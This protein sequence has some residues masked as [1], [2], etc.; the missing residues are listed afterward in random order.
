MASETAARL[1]EIDEVPAT[2]E[3]SEVSVKALQGLDWPT[4]FARDGNGPSDAEWRHDNT[5]RASRAL[6]AVAAYSTRYGASRDEPVGS[7][8]RMLLADLFHLAD[9][10]GLDLREELE[11]AAD[12]FYE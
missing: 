6:H 9:A 7:E 3:A 1:P 8:I 11:T 2:E 12:T 4:G 5:F 10:L